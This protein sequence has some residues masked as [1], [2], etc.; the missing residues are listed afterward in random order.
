[1]SN[2]TFL[3][4][5]KEV[6]SQLGLDYTE[7]DDSTLIKRWINL[8]YKDIV[9]YSNWSWLQSQEVQTTE[10]DYSSDTDTTT[11]SIASGDTTATVS[12]TISVSQTGRFIQFSSANDWY[13]ISAHTAGTDSITLSTAYAQASD[14]TDGTYNIRTRYYSLASTTDRVISARQAVSPY[15]LDIISHKTYD[16]VVPYTEA[17]G[18]PYAAFMWGQDSSGNWRY[19]LYPFPDTALLVE[20]R[21]IKKATELDGDTDTAIFPE[22]FESVWLDLACARGWRHNDDTRADVTYRQGL[23]NLKNLN[24]QDGQ[25]PGRRRVLKSIDEV[26]PM[27]GIVPFTPEYGEQP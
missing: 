8:S 19:T 23:F 1:M 11:I 3:T 27:R 4:A 6:A 20:F 26:R 13:E 18:T 15:K 21:V 14:L 9:G 16:D 2:M 17:T 22:R 12:A 25:D 10:I 24:S 5:Q 7:T